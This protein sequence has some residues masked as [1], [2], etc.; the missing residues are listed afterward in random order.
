[1]EIFLVILRFILFALLTILALFLIIIGI[2]LFNPVKY[3]IEAKI[4]KDIYAVIRCSWIF[5]VFRFCY[6][7]TDGNS[8]IILT[9][10]WVKIIGGE[11]KGIAEKERK[12]NRKSS[13]KTGPE[14]NGSQTIEISM[15]ELKSDVKEAGESAVNAVEDAVK[16]EYKEAT[17][18]SN[19][20]LNSEDVKEPE[21]DEEKDKQSWKEKLDNILD[22]CKNY[23][24]RL[25]F[26]LNYPNKKEIFDYT[27]ACLKKLL[28]ALKPKKLD[29][30]AEI[31][32]DDPAMTGY[33]I[34][35]MYA[36]KPISFIKI[37]IIGDFEKAVM[38]FTV[39]AK[40]KVKLWSLLYPLVRYALK[41]PIWE[42]IKNLLNRKEEDDEYKFEH[43][44]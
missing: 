14:K 41:K 40:G 17:D 5:G 37:D 35:L 19:Y 12:R 15:D 31:G 27:M 9:A 24:E 22:T 6:L 32:F 36:I 1:M 7:F 21:H 29:V 28:T 33:I 20:D 44:S 30:R 11:K 25:R 3:E 10:L 26:V 23:I 8:N 4:N 13:D 34:G 39:S 16:T 42:I 18:D 2:A 38:K 43:Q